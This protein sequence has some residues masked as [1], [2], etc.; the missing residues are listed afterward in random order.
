MTKMSE[1]II[2]GIGEVLWDVLQDSE[3]L[4]GAPINFAYHASAM[5][6]TGYAISAIGDDARGHKAIKELQA[7]EMSTK[8]IHTIPEATTGYVL[9]EIDVDG[10]ASYSFPDDVA[11]DNLILDTATTELSSNLHAICFGSLA[12]RT[13]CSREAIA[14]FLK[15]TGNQTLKIFD[16]NIRQNFY[17]KEVITDSLNFADVL[18][19]NDDEILLIAEME[20]LAGDNTTVLQQL[21]QKYKLKLAVLTRGGQGSLLVSPTEISEHPGYQ[22][23][24]VD[25]IG[26]GDSF[27]AATVLGLLQNEPLTTINEKANAVAAYVCSQKGAMPILPK[28][29][30]L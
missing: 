3:E 7:R 25:T 13:K 15:S 4:G 18:K 27:T 12:Q 28:H 8:Y 10:V 22:A 23:D 24:I 17:S 6:A 20:D 14:Y 30:Q 29:F 19:L 11:W 21:V 2:A 9:A 26:A 5:G 16:L 1:F